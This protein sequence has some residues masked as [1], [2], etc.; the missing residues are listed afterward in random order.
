MNRCYVSVTNSDIFIPSR[1]R[2][3]FSISSCTSQHVDIFHCNLNYSIPLFCFSLTFTLDSWSCCIKS[4]FFI[5]PSTPY[6]PIFDYYCSSLPYYN[7]TGSFLIQCRCYFIIHLLIYDYI[8]YFA[9]VAWTHIIFYLTIPIILRI[10]IDSIIANI[11][12]YACLSVHSM[13][14]FLIFNIIFCHWVQQSIQHFHSGFHF[15]IISV[16]NFIQRNMLSTDDISNVTTV[17][18]FR[19]ILYAKKVGWI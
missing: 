7:I 9:F 17:S 2:W 8:G 16:S 18:I 19:F 3:L 13:R 1:N 11:S 5:L 14:F 12:F 4:W 10:F 15:F 6:I